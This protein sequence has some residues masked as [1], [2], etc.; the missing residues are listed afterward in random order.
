MYII[1]AKGILKDKGDV[2]MM[3]AGALRKV[4]GKKIIFSFLSNENVHA[5]IRL[6]I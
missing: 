4:D 1:I 3:R 2:V 5:A 6:R